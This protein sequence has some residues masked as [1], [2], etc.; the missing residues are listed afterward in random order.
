MTLLESTILD[1]KVTIS[2]AQRGGI[3]RLNDNSHVSLDV[4]NAAVSRNDVQFEI[5]QNNDNDWDYG[6]G[7]GWLNC[8]STLKNSNKSMTT[9]DKKKGNKIVKKAVKRPI[10]HLID[11]DSEEEWK[12]NI[13]FNVQKCGNKS[14]SV[15][16]TSEI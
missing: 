7:D 8:K 9:Q 14:K 4:Q 10:V 2:E 6:D 12:E 11:D 5:H 13:N 1:M 3:N 15:D 16:L